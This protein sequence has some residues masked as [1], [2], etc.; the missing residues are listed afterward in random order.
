M[1]A[2]SLNVD[3]I[4]GGV[5]G[6]LMILTAVSIRDWIYPRNLVIVRGDAD[7]RSYVVGVSIGVPTPEHTR[8]YVRSMSLTSVC[9]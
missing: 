4:V 1:L 5:I 6:G 8:A 7:R 2:G 3:A 9:I